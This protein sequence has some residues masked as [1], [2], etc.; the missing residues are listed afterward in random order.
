MAR[1]HSRVEI[2]WPVVHQ[3]TLLAAFRT[4]RQV[5]REVENEAKVRTLIGPYTTGFLSASINTKI[6]IVKGGKAV[7]GQVGSPPVCRWRRRHPTCC[8]LS[9][10]AW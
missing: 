5:C 1:S 6:H 9:W 3:T 2:H 4:V 10:R 7:T 8:S